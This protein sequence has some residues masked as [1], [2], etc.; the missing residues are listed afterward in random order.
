MSDEAKEMAVDILEKASGLSKQALANVSSYVRGY[1]DAM[2]EKE[3]KEDAGTEN[4]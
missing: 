3:E 1:A 2:A 4:Q